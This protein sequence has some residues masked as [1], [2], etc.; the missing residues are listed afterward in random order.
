VRERERESEGVYVCVREREREREYIPKL[1]KRI[2]LI[3]VLVSLG[4]RGRE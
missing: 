4:E 2:M 3:G 1:R